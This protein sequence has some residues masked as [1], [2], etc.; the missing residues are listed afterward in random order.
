MLRHGWIL[1]SGTYLETMLPD[2]GVK[3]RQLWAILYRRLFPQTTA[4]FWIC[5]SLQVKSGHIPIRP[6]LER[7]R[8]L[9]GVATLG[10]FAALDP[11][12][13]DVGMH[14]GARLDARPWDRFVV[15][16]AGGPSD[17]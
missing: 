9:N 11:Q 12:Y 16:G 15:S 3:H 5:V 17:P 7:F 1:L 10:E 6:D 4:P 14:A 2:H 13:P 8:N